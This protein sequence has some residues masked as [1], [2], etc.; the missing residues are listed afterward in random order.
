MAVQSGFT[1]DDVSMTFTGSL[2]SEDSGAGFGPGGA[3]LIYDLRWNE[4]TFALEVQRTAGAAWEVLLQF[5]NYYFQNELG[6]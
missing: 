2:T 5:E 6:L 3:S 4:K 1:K